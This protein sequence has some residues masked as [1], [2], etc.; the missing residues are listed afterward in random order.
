LID[1]YHNQ[2]DVSLGIQIN[3]CVRFPVQSSL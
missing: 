3:A 1:G 2:M